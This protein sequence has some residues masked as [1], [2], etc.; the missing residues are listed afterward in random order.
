VAKTAT[1]VRADLTAVRVINHWLC[2]ARG[3]EQSA[4]ERD[5]LGW[6]GWPNG[7]PYDID[8][9]E[10]EKQKI[11]LMLGHIATHYTLSDKQIKALAETADMIRNSA[12]EAFRRVK[13][14]W[15]T[16]LLN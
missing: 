10:F 14:N 6:L 5:L 8:V 1:N 15:L 7:V 16:D 11:D 4:N 12:F 9:T 13:C 3:V 2:Q